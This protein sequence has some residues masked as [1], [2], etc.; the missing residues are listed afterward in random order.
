[1]EEKW[2]EVAWAA[3]AEQLRVSERYCRSL[4]SFPLI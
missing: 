4:T 3:F 1:M 2:K